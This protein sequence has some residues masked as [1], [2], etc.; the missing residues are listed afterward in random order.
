[1]KL[2]HC[3]R[4]K[5]YYLDGEKLTKYQ[6]V[7]LARIWLDKLFHKYLDISYVKFICQEC[8]DS[9]GA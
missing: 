7:L 6:R 2:Y 1:M 4:C 8:L 5:E 9:K 3:I